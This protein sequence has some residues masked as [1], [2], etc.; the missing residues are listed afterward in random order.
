M[1]CGVT[2]FTRIASEIRKIEALQRGDHW[3][4]S[5]T[6]P[7]IDGEHL[8]ISWEHK[9]IESMAISGT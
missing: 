9:D 4:S 2:I 5:H 3:S 7:W 6:E 1:F 8:E